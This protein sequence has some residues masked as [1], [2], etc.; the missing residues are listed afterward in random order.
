MTET[1]IFHMSF[2]ECWVH[3]I[4]SWSIAR[5]SAQLLLPACGLIWWM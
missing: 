4:R 1:M 3:L 2:N 5:S